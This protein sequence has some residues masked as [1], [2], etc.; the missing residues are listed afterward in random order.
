[1]GMLT[2]ISL[3][4]QTLVARTSLAVVGVHHRRGNGSGTVIT[5]DG[6]VLTNS[7]VVRDPRRLQVRLPGADDVPAELLGS[8][9][10]TDLAVVRMARPVEAHLSLADRRAVA[11]GELVVAIGNPLGLDRS[12]SLGVVSAVD[13]SLQSGGGLHEGLLQTDCAIN[14]GNSGG[15]LLSMEGEVL[16]VNTIMIPYAQGIGFAIPART[17]SWVAAV[18]IREGEVRRP[19]LGISAV[20]EELPP[21]ASQDAGQ[22]RAVRIH[23]V[24]D[25]PA[26]RAGLRAGDLLL[27]CN[28]TPLGSV[29]DLQRVMV[30]SGASEIALELL[31][32][33]ERRRVPVRPGPPRASARSSEASEERE[34]RPRGA[35]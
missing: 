35:K 18:L 7:H 32:G 14:P 5:D 15:P 1:M 9:D 6:I 27:L 3:E 25:G 23:D 11:T 16:G 19:Y 4:L 8:D 31:R 30:L 22:P 24:G 20:G 33:H 13:R 10:R 34:L 26:G 12:V 29:D 2:Q 28:G 21:S 17:A